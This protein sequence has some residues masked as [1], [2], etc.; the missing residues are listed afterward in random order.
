MGVGGRI[1]SFIIFQKVETQRLI[2]TAEEE[3][4]GCVFLKF[5][6]ENRGPEKG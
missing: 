3:E 2:T 6:K 4:N 1:C 5:E